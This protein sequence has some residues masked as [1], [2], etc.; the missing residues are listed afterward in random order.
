[1]NLSKYKRGAMPNTIFR[2]GT[3]FFLAL[4]IVMAGFTRA[5]A[6]SAVAST[7]VPATAEVP[8][9]GGLEEIVVTAQKRS[10]AEQRTPISMTVISGED[11]NQKSIIDVRE[12]QYLSPSLT[13]AQSTNSQFGSD[14]TIRG[15][16]SYSSEE[17]P[18]G[19]Y[20]DGVYVA[21]QTSTGANAAGFTSLLDVTRVEVLKG[22]Q[23]TLYGRNTAAGAINFYSTLPTDQLEGSVD[24]S[25]GNDGFQEYTTILNLPLVTDKVLS[26]FAV[27]YGSSDGFQPN[28]QGGDKLGAYER[29]ATKGTV[30]FN[31]TSDLS[32]AL[33]G[34]YAKATGPGH[35]EQ[36]IAVQPGSSFVSEVA[37]E[38]GLPQTAAGLAAAQGIIARYTAGPTGSLATIEATRGYAYYE[39]Y[40]TSLTGDYKALDWLDIKS[41]TG[42]RRLTANAGNDYDVTPFSGL[43]GVTEGRLNQFTQELTM[44]GAG[45]DQR[46]QYAAG[47]YYY[48]LTKIDDTIATVTPLLDPDNPNSTLL[49][50]GDKSY[51]GFAQV[52][53]TVV[54]DLNFTGG[55]RYTKEDKTL[56]SRSHSGAGCLVPVAN[57]IG[58][59]CEGIFDTS[60]SN[61]SYTIGLDYQAT[62]NIL[63][64][65]KVATGFRAGGTNGGSS[66]PGSYNNFAPETT[67]TYETG[68]KSEFLDNRLR[69]NL[70]YYF[71]NYKDLQEAVYVVVPP[72]N[73]LLSVTTN[74]AKARIQGLE[75][76]T[77]VE[78]L[79]NLVVNA[80]AGYTDP[81]FLDYSDATGDH[82][83]EKFDDTPKFTYSLS[84]DYAIPIDA[85]RRLRT[86]VDWYWRSGTDLAPQIQTAPR[87]TQFQPGYGL[88]NS[89][90]AFDIDQYGLTVALFGKNL[91]DRRYLTNVTTQY[92]TLGYVVGGAG[93][94]RTFGVDVHKKF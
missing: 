39:N 24:L 86:E 56:T 26:R 58:G 43:Y 25:G 52:T 42:Y 83:G 40:G 32:F 33:R 88:L 47:V 7:A 14:F 87:Y 70:T 17:S 44:S 79:P 66:V 22:P 48:D 53:Y 50:I 2:L 78:P 73:A 63:V 64:Y 91:A 27:Q 90:L 68:I 94:P 76:N 75:F 46:L 21:A 37:G 54:P 57:Q 89:R 85:G 51:S 62:Q 65:A 19:V 5:S 4:A 20:V 84:S 77:A 93:D 41:I 29:I 35:Q 1:M 8:A 10:Q 59:Q 82:T 55:I 30:L 3:T 9:A 34:D 81:R 31:A 67:T 38:S 13:I 16:N 92:G 60:F 12:I 49:D 61:T 11:L 71:T 74:A 18:I 69:L 28:L 45:F 36:L 23:G 72:S 6:Q 15:I 80:T